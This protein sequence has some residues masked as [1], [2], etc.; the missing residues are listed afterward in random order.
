MSHVR[1]V[2]C[3]AVVGARS[4]LLNLPAAGPAASRTTSRSSP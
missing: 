4:S 3:A 2:A 1:Q